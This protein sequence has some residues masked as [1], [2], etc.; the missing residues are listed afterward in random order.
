MAADDRKTRQTAKR[1][2]NA[3][4]LA[5]VTLLAAASGM[6]GMARQAVFLGPKPG[7]IIAFDPAR[8]HPSAN[9]VRLIAGQASQKNCVLDLD[10]I[11]RWGGSLVIEQR[12][13]APERLYRA[14]WAGPGTSDDMTDC[15]PAADLLLSA[16]DVSTLAAAAGGF[17]AARVPG[18]P[19]SR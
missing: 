10:T 13:P 11:R 8:A 18:P 6:T 2:P 16:A 19:L 3:V 7:D 14:H 4:L 5:S 9:G 17:G 1:I 15:G 12:G